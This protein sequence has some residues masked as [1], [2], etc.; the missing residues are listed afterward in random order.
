MLSMTGPAYGP[1]PCL[2]PSV[3]TSRQGPVKRA[4]LMGWGMVILFPCTL[5]LWT[6]ISSEVRKKFWVC[7]LNFCFQRRVGEAGGRGV[8]RNWMDSCQYLGQW[9]KFLDMSLCYCRSHLTSPRAYSSTQRLNASW[10]EAVAFVVLATWPF[11]PGTFHHFLVKKGEI[12]L[13]KYGGFSKCHS[14]NNQS[15]TKHSLVSFLCAFPAAFTYLGMVISFLSK[16]EWLCP[17]NKHLQIQ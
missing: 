9:V 2:G 4:W 13:I 8:A 3:W 15:S 7:W 1:L 17:E 10:I 14:W 6:D 16:I 12:Y 11:F 5:L